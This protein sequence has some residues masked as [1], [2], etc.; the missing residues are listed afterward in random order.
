MADCLDSISYFVS[1]LL[2]ERIVRE[3]RKMK[4]YE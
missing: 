2:N 4:Q 3:V 1:T